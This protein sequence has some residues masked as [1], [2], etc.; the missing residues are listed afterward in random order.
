MNRAHYT[1]QLVDVSD[2]I[3]DHL[4]DEIDLFRLAEI[5]HLS[6]YH[7]H[8]VYHAMSGETA[9]ST[10]R[11]LR[12][13]RAAGYLADT[14]MPVREVARRSGFA[15][16]E[17]FSRS[18][19]EAYGIPP[20]RFRATGDHTLYRAT[21]DGPAARLPAHPVG[22]RRIEQRV[23]AASPHRGAFVDIGRAFT[24]AREGIGASAGGMVAVY[25]DDP[26]GAPEPELR[27]AAGIEIAA[28]D[29]VPSQLE[30]IVLP[31]GEY[32]VLAYR[33]PYASMR[34]AYTW[35]YGS[36]LPQ[37]GRVPADHPVVERYLNDPAVTPPGE[38]RTDI[39]VLLEE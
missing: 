38:L 34:S 1:R 31:A 24:R 33:G 10:V 19:R 13:Q 4:D 32:A 15:S 16:T 27:S 35:F 20:A 5:A 12:L 8:R 14:T 29:P 9:A 7:W 30:R 6:S 2:Y 18:F 36:W 26:D 25:Y 28:D 22:L 3:Y 21:A 11:R 17:V 23:I 37:S 39:S